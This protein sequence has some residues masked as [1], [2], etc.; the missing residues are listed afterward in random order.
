MELCCVGVDG[1]E[2]RGDER[3]ILGVCEHWYLVA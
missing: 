1:R 2:V 3:D